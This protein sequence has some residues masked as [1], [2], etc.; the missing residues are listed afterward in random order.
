MR[1][2]SE[3]DFPPKL[4]PGESQSKD[5]YLLGYYARKIFH[6]ACKHLLLNRRRARATM[7]M[8]SDPR[9]FLYV[10]MWL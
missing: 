1:G 8:V 10:P 5:L 2:T 7:R 3:G 9:Y 4:K 6:G